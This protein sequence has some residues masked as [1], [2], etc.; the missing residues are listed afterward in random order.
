[1]I[2]SPESWRDVA[3]ITHSPGR[4]WDGLGVKLGSAENIPG[5]S[6]VHDHMDYPPA[7]L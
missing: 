6:S 3:N 7:K 2:G 1:M 4:V 5:V